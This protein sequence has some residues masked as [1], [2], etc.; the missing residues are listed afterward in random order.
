MEIGLK[1]PHIGDNASPQYVREFAQAAEENGF[2]SVWVADHVAVPHRS[3]SVYSLSDPPATPPDGAL[4][5]VLGPNFESLTTLAFAA[6]ITRRIRLGTSVAV[7]PLRHPLLNAKMLATIDCYSGGRLLYGAGAGWL[8]EEAEAIGM[9]W[10]HRGARMEEHIAILRALWTAPGPYVDFSGTYYSFHG[11]DSSPRPAQPQGPPI[12]IG[13]HSDVALARA[14]RIG[15]GWIAS[16]LNPD[17]LARMFDRVIVA[18]IRA[19]RDPAVLRLHANV[20]FSPNAQLRGYA[21]VSKAV[22]AR[23]T[24]AS[25]SA[26]QEDPE[27]IADQ[28]AAY[29][30]AGVHHVRLSARMASPAA[31]L[32]WV[33]QL[34]AHVVPRVH[35]MPEKENATSLQR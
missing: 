35:A 31:E 17:R 2:D 34:G 28:L 26:P 27:T 1:L 8:R 14:G 5:A 12:L 30:R 24:T 7:L 29:A 22:A 6:G 21:V 32:A 3:A 18:A 19:D 15:D 20:D 11:I 13:G 16:R 10:D 33:Q 23:T 25:G 4:S 9:P